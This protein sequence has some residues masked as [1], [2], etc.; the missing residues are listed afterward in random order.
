VRPR[1]FGGKTVLQYMKKNNLDLERILYDP[2]VR[3]TGRGMKA[4]V[5]AF[6]A[7]LLE[8]ALNLRC[9]DGQL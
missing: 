3:G 2:E 7:T 4:I 6:N 9:S 5:A 1:N 8:N